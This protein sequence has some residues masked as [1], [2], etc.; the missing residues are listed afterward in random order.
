MSIHTAPNCTMPQNFNAT[1]TLLGSSNCDAIATGDTGKVQAY[2]HKSVDIDL[3][4]PLG[5]GIESDVPNNFGAPFN[6]NGGGVFA[7]S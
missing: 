7:S 1:G 4:S 2:R 6:N 5:C 3:L